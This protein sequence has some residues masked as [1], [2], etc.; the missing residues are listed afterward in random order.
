MDTV[1]LCGAAIGIMFLVYIFAF[2]KARPGWQ[3]DKGFNS[4]DKEDE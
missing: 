2:S 1:Y 3:D 4:G